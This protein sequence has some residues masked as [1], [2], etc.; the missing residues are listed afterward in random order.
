MCHWCISSVGQ[1]GGR[2]GRLEQSSSSAC[3]DHRLCHTPS[4][5]GNLVSSPPGNIPH[6]GVILPWTVPAWTQATQDMS[7][8]RGRKV[9]LPKR[10]LFKVPFLEI[11]IC[12]K[13]VLKRYWLISQYNMYWIETNIVTLQWFDITTVETQSSW[14]LSGRD[15]GGTPPRPGGKHI[16]TPPAKVDK[17]RLKRWKVTTWWAAEPVRWKNLADQ[18]DVSDHTVNQGCP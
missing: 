11:C 3:G 16:E 18:S 6:I 10:V 17:H 13:K 9:L 14:S 4:P 12:P 7:S 8:P 15:C 2:G 1:C 5:P